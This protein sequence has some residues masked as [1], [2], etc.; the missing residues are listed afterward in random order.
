MNK[1]TRGLQTIQEEVSNLGRKF[2]YMVYIHNIYMLY[3][4]H[5]CVGVPYK[6]E[7]I[8]KSRLLWFKACDI[9]TVCDT[10]CVYR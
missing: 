4:V 3:V 8:Y 5:Q 2:K 6:K 10:Q 1:H 7:I 9:Y